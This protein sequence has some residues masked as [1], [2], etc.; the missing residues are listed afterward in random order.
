MHVKN[1][2]AVISNKVF[3][4]YRLAAQLDQF[5]TYVTSWGTS[6]IDTDVGKYAFMQVVYNSDKNNAFILSYGAE[7]DI[8]SGFALAYLHKTGARSEVYLGYGNRSD[9]LEEI[10]GVES[11]ANEQ[12]VL[13]MGWSARFR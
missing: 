4:P 11:A 13:T 2:V 7:G 1:Q 10:P 6:L 5:P 12:S 9:D 3:A 8:S